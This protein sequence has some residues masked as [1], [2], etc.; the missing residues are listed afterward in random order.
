MS[1]E[2]MANGNNG[3]W[4][5]TTLYLLESSDNL[6]LTDIQWAVTY[7]RGGSGALD[8]QNPKNK[9]TKDIEIVLYIIIL[10]YTI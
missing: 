2:Y 4:T 1:N 5:I 10:V 3:H 9:A 6:G 8:P 7:L